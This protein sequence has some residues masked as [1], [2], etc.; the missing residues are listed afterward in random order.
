MSA[1][2]HDETVNSKGILSGL[3]E[4]RDLPDWFREQQHVALEKFESIPRP[5]RKDQPW[6]FSNVDLLD[7]APFK[8]SGTVSDQARAAIL[9]Q[10]NGLDEVAA[11]LVFAGDQLLE[12]DVVSEQLSKRGVIFQPLERAMVEHADLFRKYFMSTE[13]S[14]GSAKFAAL[15]QALVSTGTFLFVPRGVEIDQPIEIF[16]WLAGENATVFPHLLLVTDEL[17]K[18]TVIEHFRSLDRNQ[19]GFAC[20]V[21][22]LLAGPGAKV[23]Y[24]CAQN[25]GDKV[26]A[27]QMN[28]TAVDHDASAMSLNLNLGSRYSRFES[29]S[30]L[31]GEGARSD[32]LA[33]AVATN[34]Q[35]FDART[36]QDH[37]SPH[38]ASDLLYK[39]ALDDRARCTFGG[40]IR[41][42]PHAHFTDAYQKVR[43]LLL[44]DDSEANS[45]PGLEILADNVRCTHG[46]T[47]GQINEEELF[48][49]HSRGIPT[50]TAQRLIVT[51][52]LNEVI[53]RLD[54]PAIADYL[55]QLI[56]R[57]FAHSR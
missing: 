15:H 20:G 12:R 53:R 18:V 11:R 28:T 27:L 56:D 22:D 36:L 54:Q 41:V 13:V 1:I 45:M 37:I 3:L 51:G 6:R 30:R 57:K 10:S 39:N 17:A 50:K 7:L 8:L 29:L 48:Y 34:E 4:L 16:H 19:R 31:V 32:L 40:L 5:T 49:L 55:N 26:V 25:W 9:E 23:T 35:E 42:E 43:N 52:F 14:L 21:N 38:T 47:S 46:A 24:V 44:S 2:A 33:V